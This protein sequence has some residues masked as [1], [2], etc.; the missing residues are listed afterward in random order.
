MPAEICVRCREPM[1]SWR[2]RRTIILPPLESPLRTAFR[3]LKDSIVVEH[4]CSRVE[5]TWLAE[6]KKRIQK[7][8]YWR[9]NGHFISA[10]P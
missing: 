7:K 3:V 5:P 10:I 6:S 4:Y 2:S 9:I 1:R 8:K